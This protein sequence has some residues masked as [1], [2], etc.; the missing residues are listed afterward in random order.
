MVLPD[1]PSEPI[2]IDKEK[3][4]GANPVH[5]RHG[6]STSGQSQQIRLGN[7]W[8]MHGNHRPRLQQP[9]DLAQVDRVAEIHF[10]GQ[11]GPLAEPEASVWD[12]SVPVENRI[13][14]D[15]QIKVD[16]AAGMFCREL[17]EHTK[18]A[19]GIMKDIIFWF[20]L[21]VFGVEGVKSVDNSQNK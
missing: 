8:L 3:L 6:H 4:D 12:P 16:A 10:P 17:F 5:A 21:V 1:I 11:C 19:R 20:A 18:H 13:Q 9:D 15:P 14:E 7:L 2:V